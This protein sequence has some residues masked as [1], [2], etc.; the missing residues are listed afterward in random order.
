MCDDIHARRYGS[1]DTIV[2]EC[3]CFQ[4][5]VLFLV[6]GYDYSYV[7]TSAPNIAATVPCLS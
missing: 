5:D 2:S 6:G 1:G 3:V 4:R 7:N